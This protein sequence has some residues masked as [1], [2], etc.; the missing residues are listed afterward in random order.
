MQPVFFAQRAGHGIDGKDSF[1]KRCPVEP[2]SLVLPRLV[3]LFGST[4]RIVPS[5]AELRAWHFADGHEVL[6][7]TCPVRPH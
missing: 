7:F 1:E 5:F 4:S 2:I 6:I 3:Q